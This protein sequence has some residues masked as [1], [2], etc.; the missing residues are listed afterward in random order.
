MNRCTSKVMCDLHRFGDKEN[1]NQ[2]ICRLCGER[3]TLPATLVVQQYQIPCP[4]GLFDEEVLQT[5][6]DQQS[7]DSE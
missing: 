2:W 3:Y 6:T 5:N 7:R 1:P 4:S